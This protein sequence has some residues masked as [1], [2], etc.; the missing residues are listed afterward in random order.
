[1]QQLGNLKR[2]C[3]LLQEDLTRVLFLP[4]DAQK[5]AIRSAKE[6]LQEAEN[7]VRSRA[8]LPLV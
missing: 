8:S 2:D 5:Q 1:V 6:Q 3:V 4:T 7:Y